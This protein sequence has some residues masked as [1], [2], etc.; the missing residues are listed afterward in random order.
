[1]N[2]RLNS[3]VA[4]ANDLPRRAEPPA[5]EGP[6]S[7]F[8]IALVLLSAGSVLL[9]TILGGQLGG[10]A[11]VLAAAVGALLLVVVVRAALRRAARD[12]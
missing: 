9:A 3:V 7:T 6:L 5:Q 1:M 4:V 2:N 8:G 12:Q 11:T 10:V